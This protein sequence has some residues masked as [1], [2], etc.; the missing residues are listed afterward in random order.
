ML[1]KQRII[2]DKAGTIYFD[3]PEGRP[4]VATVTVKTN[5]G[6]D[7]P[8]AAVEDANATIDTV[9]TTIAAGWVATAPRTVPLASATGVTVGRDYLIT[10][11]AG[12]EE[13]VHITALSGTTATVRSTPGFDLTTG[14][15]FVGTRLTIAITAANAATRAHNYRC[16]WEYTVG[17]VQ[18]EGEN[19]FDIVRTPPKNPAT[20]AGARG[21]APEL[22]SE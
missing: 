18:Y 1:R 20:T 4:S 6:G 17:G 22:L 3:C 19:L 9:T 8:D 15:T 7:L 10:T 21:Y 14:D 11:A 2:E 16:A 12:R 13:W 5:K